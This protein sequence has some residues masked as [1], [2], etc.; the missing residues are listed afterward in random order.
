MKKILFLFTLLVGQSFFA[1]E[2]ETRIN[3]WYGTINNS[4]IEEHLALEKHFKSVWKQQKEAGLLANWEMWQ[5]L[6][7]N[8]ASTETTYLYVKFY[9]EENRKKSA[10]ISGIP[11]GLDAETWDIITDT[12]MSHFKKIYSTDVSYKGGFNNSVEGTK[13]ADY[14]IINSMNVDWYRQADY[15]SMELKTFMPINKKNGMNAWAL[16]KVLDQFGTE[17]KINYYTVDFFDTLEEIYTMRSNTSKMNKSDVDANK[18]MDQIRS[19]LS[20]DIFKRIDYLD[21]K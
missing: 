13:P 19:L 15:E 16:T 21:K 12:Q 10:S 17:R 1:Q 7:P 18:K 20:S 8:E 3:M 14:A 4:D 2:G 5:L 6:N 11:E 9:A